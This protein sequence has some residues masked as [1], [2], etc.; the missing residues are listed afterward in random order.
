[1]HEEVYQPLGLGARDEC[2]AI[3]P[4]GEVPETHRA[5]DMGQRLT[6]GTTLDGLLEA[7]Q[8][9]RIRLAARQQ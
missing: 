6:P 4:Q 8:H 9:R 7:G 2:S 3:T 5:H 1:L